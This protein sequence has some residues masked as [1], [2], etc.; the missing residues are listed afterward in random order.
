MASVLKVDQLQLSDGS[1]PT[2]GDLG[3]DITATDMP[4]GTIVSCYY[5]ECTANLTLTTTSNVLVPDY[6]FTVTPKKLGNKF[7]IIA[8]LHTYVGQAGAND[9]AAIP[10]KIYKDGSQI[11]SSVDYGTGII[12][13]GDA[14]TRMMVQT[15]IDTEDT[16]TSLTSATYTVAARMRDDGAHTGV[17]NQYGHGSFTIYEIS[18]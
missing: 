4:T 2:A 14:A 16:P 6:S 3:I 15:V 7:V 13:G 9:W 5:K 17:I 18:A 11:S 1:T 10:C 12:D 8:N